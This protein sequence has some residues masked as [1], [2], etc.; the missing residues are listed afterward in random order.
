[1][2]EISFV[3]IKTDFVP[4]LHLFNK[5]VYLFQFEIYDM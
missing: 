5:T 2:D 3:N 4:N 1:M